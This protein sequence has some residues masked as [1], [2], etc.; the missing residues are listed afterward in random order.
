MKKEYFLY[1]LAGIAASLT[2]IYLY[3]KLNKKE[4]PID[5]LLI[6]CTDTLQLSNFKQLVLLVEDKSFHKKYHNLLK[7]FEEHNK[8]DAF[9]IKLEADKRN[10]INI[11]SNPIFRYSSMF[12]RSYL[13]QMI[14]SF[15]QEIKQNSLEIMAY[16]DDKM[17]MNDLKNELKKQ[18]VLF[19]PYT[20]KYSVM[21]AYHHISDELQKHKFKDLNFL[22]WSHGHGTP[23]DHFANLS[24]ILV[25][26]ILNQLNDRDITAKVILLGTCFSASFLTNF[27]QIQSEKSIVLSHSGPS[28][29]DYLS[30]LSYFLLRKNW[31]HSTNINDQYQH[32]LKLNPINY[33]DEDESQCITI[34]DQTFTGDVIQ[35]QP[36]MCNDDLLMIK[37]INQFNQTQII[38]LSQKEFVN[39]VNIMVSQLFEDELSK[40]ELLFYQQQSPSTSQNQMTC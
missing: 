28:T 8:N 19:I 1:A 20:T 21:K 29:N 2:T 33:S 11:E 26:D 13:T 39:L 3:K 30:T 4:K 17:F 14:H 37:L 24:A 6:T 10:L 34:G 31:L 38:D 22:C 7:L 15:S 25:K 9:L 35:T 23:F 32:L 36:H 5:N 40:N 16:L 27:S 12:R 18:G